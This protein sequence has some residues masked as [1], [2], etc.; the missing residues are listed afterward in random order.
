MPKK[1]PLHEAINDAF[2]N[3]KVY[4]MGCYSASKMVMING[5]LDYFARVRPDKEKLD[6]AEA[7]LLKDKTPLRYPEPG[8]TWDFVKS[9]TPEELKLPGTVLTVVKGIPPRNFVAG[10]WSYILNTDEPSS[11]EPGY[12]GSNAV[13]LGRNNF[14]DYYSETKYD[15][16]TFE[17]KIDEV[18]QWRN[19]ILKDL[20]IVPLLF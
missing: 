11:N 1:L 12:E 8:I 2:I 15:H 13:Y 18:Y 4:G 16:Y 7:I 14:D 10:D 20:R 6:R 19:G 3:Q 17:E 9:M 5:V